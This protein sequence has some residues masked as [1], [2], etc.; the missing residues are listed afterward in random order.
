MSNVGQSAPDDGAIFQALEQTLPVIVFVLDADGTVHD[1]FANDRT[2]DL[3]YDESS[4][5]VGQELDDFFEP[6]V[7]SRFETAITE[8]L[9]TDTAREIE[10]TLPVRAGERTFI[11][12]IVPIPDGTRERVLWVADDVTERRARLQELERYETFLESIQQLVTVVD[13]D[14]TITYES[15]S[16]EELHGYEQDERVGDLAFDYIHPDDWERVK[17]H[18]EQ[19][20]EGSATSGPI[21]YRAKNKDGSWSWVESQGRILLDTPAVEGFVVTTRKIGERKDQEQA[22]R[23]SHD[24]LSR[25]EEM[26]DVG[27][28]ELDLETETL[29]WSGG[30]RHIHE[31]EEDFEPD[32][33][34][35]IEFYHP[36]DR[37]T[38]RRAV[39]Q[40]RELGVPYDIEA[41]IITEEGRTRWVETSG[42]HVEEDGRRLIRGA[43]RDITDQ[44]EREERLM[45]LNRVLRHN[46]RNDLNVVIGYAELIGDTVADLEIPSV[47][48]EAPSEQ[49]EEQVAELGE[50]S[51]TL[52]EAL[53]TLDTLHDE[54]SSFPIEDILRGAERIETTSENLMDIAKKAQRFEHS[55]DRGQIVDTVEIW[56]VL[57]DLAEKYGDTYEEA[58]IEL[59]GD[60]ATIHGDRLA[61]REILEELIE[62]A[63]IHSN[64]E[65]PNVT[66]RVSDESP[67]WVQVWVEDDGPGIP[68]MER[69]AIECGEETPLMHGSGIGLWLVN[70]LVTRLGGSITIEDNEPTGTI[71][72]IQF[73]KMRGKALDA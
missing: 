20:V 72:S 6:E 7:A 40:C 68:Q 29:S 4:A 17:D 10:Y 65:T 63:I 61:I 22:R 34:S 67:D 32:V 8:V 30:V 2:Q 50:M 42:E 36:E 70:W 47:I 11:A 27:G 60:I 18:L 45:V 39:D 24:L 53:E 21:E 62:N 64:R 44:R 43:I 57:Q 23:R 14:G 5:L 71:V 46:L 38:V 51:T 35:A 19:R 13:E 66:L 56:G 55:F 48:E 69:E 54:L 9:K 31:V 73:P 1:V 15:P 52:G 37:P 16:L 25:T 3:L 28:W 12:H 33:E 58:S 41:R 26:A 59:E 49:F